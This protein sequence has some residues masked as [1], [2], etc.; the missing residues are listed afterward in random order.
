M[1]EPKVE[2]G[3]FN[4]ENIA[5]G[6]SHKQENQ[7]W[8]VQGLIAG[9]DA[10][11]TQ[12]YL[13]TLIHLHTNARKNYAWMSQE[14]L[15]REM[16]TDLSTVKRAFRWGKQLGVIGV[17]R[18]RTGKG[19]DD[20]Y[21]EY[22]LELERL[23]ELQRPTKQ[24]ASTPLAEDEHSAST[25]LAQNGAGGKSD[26]SK[27]QITL[28]QGANRAEAR[29]T[30]DLV[31]F[32]VKQV[33]KKAAVRST[34]VEREGACIARF[35]QGHAAE[36]G[37][38]LTPEERQKQEQTAAA[39]DEQFQDR[40]TLRITPREIY[41]LWDTALR[42]DWKKAWVTKIIREHYNVEQLRDLSPAQF[43]T[44]LEILRCKPKLN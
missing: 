16:C 26:S 33:D 18:V 7:W 3:R 30:S 5:Q 37:R 10:T 6:K 24:G 12:K 35:C 22:W 32:E 27:G 42:N 9:L 4:V 25:P 19:K 31:G 44:L 23:K 38:A 29:G 41:I 8:F 34:A 11:P 40:P 13:L 28:E 15:A 17:R 36:E 39:T 2:R 21:N 20:Q 1:L 43:Q 14:S